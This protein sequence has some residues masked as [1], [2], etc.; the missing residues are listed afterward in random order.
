LL[1]TEIDA[2][3]RRAGVNLSGIEWEAVRDMSAAYA[4]ALADRNPLSIPPVERD[5]KD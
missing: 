3:A 1:W 2:F 4:A 5:Q